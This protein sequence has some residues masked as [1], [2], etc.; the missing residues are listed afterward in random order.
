MPQT[1]TELPEF[2]VITTEE[3]GDELLVWHDAYLTDK[4]CVS[5]VYLRLPVEDVETVVRAALQVPLNSV[6]EEEEIA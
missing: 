5:P 4:R 2:E 1:A 3:R 6:E